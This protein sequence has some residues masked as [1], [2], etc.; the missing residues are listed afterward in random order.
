MTL[1]QNVIAG[2][3]PQPIAPHPHCQALPPSVEE[4]EDEDGAP[5]GG[6]DEDGTPPG[7]DDDDDGRIIGFGWPDDE[8]EHSDA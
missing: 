2:K 4:D 6:D 5:P 3:A 1:L 8:H 7:G